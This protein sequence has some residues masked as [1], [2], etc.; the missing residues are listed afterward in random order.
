[1][2]IEGSPELTEKA[3]QADKIPCPARSAQLRP[4][5]HARTRTVRGLCDE[6][7]TQQPRCARCTSCRRTQVLLP[8]AL[9]ARRAADTLEVIGTAMAAQA[10]GSGHRMIAT[11]MGR[12]LSAGRRWGR[13]VPEHHAHWLYEQA[14]QHAFRLKPDT[15]VRRM[16]WPN[17]LGW[18]L[19]VLAGAALAHCR[20]VGPELPPWTPGGLFKRGNLLSPPLRT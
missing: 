12:P 14:V 9:S 15:L 2:M 1:M 6:R 17:L 13:R 16:R 3:L 19:N 8:T 18:S 4:H 7:L 10:V 11:Q 5:G 20:R